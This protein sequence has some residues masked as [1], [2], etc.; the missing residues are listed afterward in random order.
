MLRSGRAWSK[1]GRD[2]DSAVSERNS[3]ASSSDRAQYLRTEF[4]D[5][6]AHELRGPVGVTLGALDELEL[7]LGDSAGEYRTLLDMA[8][9]GVRKVLR[10]AE[11]LT[12]T[13]QLESGNVTFLPAPCDVKG[14]VQRASAEAELLERRRGVKLELILPD[15]PCTVT[16]DAAWVQA[17]LME[18]VAQALRSARRVVTVE[19]EGCPGSARIAVCDD[20]PSTATPPSHRFEPRA[21]RRDAGLSVPLASEIARAHGGELVLEPVEPNGMRTVMT[22]GGSR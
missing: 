8:R 22:F 17:A 19:L 11:R 9:R 13:A 18:V 3:E 6:V 21:D 14:L 7:A 4:L 20:G 10:T 16:L 1:G 12:R 2:V 5:R 15:Q